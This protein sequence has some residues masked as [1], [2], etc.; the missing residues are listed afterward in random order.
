M[1]DLECPAITGTTPL[2]STP[3]HP[4]HL[5]AL[6]SC[7]IFLIVG[8]FLFIASFD[9]VHIA[10][11]G[12]LHNTYSSEIE[13]KPWNSG[14]YFLGLGK[15]FIKFPKEIKSV[16]FLTA[17]DSEVPKTSIQDLT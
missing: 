3:M 17:N 11:Y 12:L 13:R 8:L 14:R 2:P 5:L 7:L 4:Y 9:A 1:G 6:F 16:E 10:E 15:K